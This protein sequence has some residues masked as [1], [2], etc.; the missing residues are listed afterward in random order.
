MSTQLNWTELIK[1]RKEGLV[2]KSTVYNI[3]N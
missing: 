1:D 2:Q 3:C